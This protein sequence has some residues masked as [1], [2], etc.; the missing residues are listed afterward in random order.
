MYNFELYN[1]WNEASMQLGLELISKDGGAIYMMDPISQEIVG[2]E[3]GAEQHFFFMLW[4]P[5]NKLGIVYRDLE[6]RDWNHALH[7]LKD[8]HSDFHIEA[9]KYLCDDQSH[10]DWFPEINHKLQKDI[11]VDDIV[12]CV[13]R[14][15][16]RDN[17][18][19]WQTFASLAS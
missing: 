10:Y 7:T 12:K 11:S 18:D 17:H 16:D 2:K 6:R 19:K 1:R 15:R 13:L 3:G 5:L 14:I 4:T 8:N 9:A